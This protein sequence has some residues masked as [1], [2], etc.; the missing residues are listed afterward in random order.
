[1]LRGREDGLTFVEMLIAIVLMSLVVFTFYELIGVAVRGWGALEGQLDVQQ[2]PR[3]ALTRI[4]NEVR[5]ARDFV[6]GGGGRELGLAKATILVRDAAAG[7]NTLEVED[8]SVLASGMPLAIQ[9][10]NRLERATV[11]GISG[12]TV[13]LSSNLARPHRRGELVLRARTTL[14]GPAAAGLA[15]FTVVDGSVLRA[16]DLASLGDEGPLRVIVVTGA[17]V[18]VAA[19]LT[20]T[21]PNAEAVQPLSVMFQC[22]GTCLDPGAQL[23]R[24]TAQCT[25]PANRIPLADLLAAPA[26]R[27]LFAAATSTL[28]APLVRG[29]RQVCLASVS[30]FASGDRV[31]IGREVHGPAAAD[32]P[33]RRVVIAIAGSCLT[34]DRGVVRTYP[35]GEAV[36][37]NA[38]DL[39]ARAFRANEV[40]GGQ[41]QEVIVTA[42]AGPRY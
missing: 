28:T 22:E 31:Q 29:D 37:V 11:A 20:Q 40:I 2:Q 42:K 26:G 14:N 41:V 16:G 32:L 3:V 24:C 6:I 25:V 23:T 33:D 30:G 10:L 5:Q 18:T 9:S 19:P 39:S 27:T 38:V 17:V 8:A 12:T 4:S 7:S 15:S 1:M 36:R 35:L 21:H 34:L 13:T